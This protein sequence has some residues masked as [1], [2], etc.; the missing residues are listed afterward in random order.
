MTY[1]TD[2]EVNYRLDLSSNVL[3]Q[4]SGMIENC[5]NRA[6]RWIVHQFARRGEDAPDVPAEGESLDDDDKVLM[7][8]EA[9]MSAYFYRRDRSEFSDEEKGYKVL[10]WKR[11]AEDLLNDYLRS[12]YTSTY[13]GMNS[14]GN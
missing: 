8:I 6:Y 12:K 5:R 11:N 10:V 9:D 3:S 7:D 1:S 14:G 4:H 13:Y 2:A